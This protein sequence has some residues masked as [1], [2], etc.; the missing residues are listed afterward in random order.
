MLALPSA[1]LAQSR[2][3]TAQTCTVHVTGNINGYHIQGCG[4][5]YLRFH[6][7]LTSTN[8]AVDLRR[9]WLKSSWPLF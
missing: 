5:D 7:R 4:G 9:L 2:Q 6:V 3:C 8:P 1:V